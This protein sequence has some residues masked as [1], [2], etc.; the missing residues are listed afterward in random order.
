MH[1]ASRLVLASL[2]L[3][4]GAPPVMAADPPMAPPIVVAPDI[5]DWTGFYIGAHVGG[6]WGSKGWVEVVGPIPGGEI[7]PTYSGLL[8]G[9]QAGADYQFAN[10]AVIGAEGDLSWT[11]ASGS[12]GCLADPTVTCGVDLDWLATG[13][14]RVGYAAGPEGR[15]L[16]YLEGGAVFVN[17]TYVVAPG[18]PGGFN[19]QDSDIG[20][21]VGAGV[22]VA[23]TD[24]WSGKL[25][26]NYNDFGT[27]RLEF[28]PGVLVQDITQRSHVVKLG[29][30][31]R[32]S[33]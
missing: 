11:N 13:T 26:Y 23:F 4:A 27:D 18:A 2:I 19:F 33:P 7:N 9:V 21:T 3:A 12:T 8:A 10:R 17:E 6:L 16:P 15:V 32:F 25:E 14:I 28:I 20:W 29:I 31:Y 30:N 5:Y 22:E 1:T 24:N